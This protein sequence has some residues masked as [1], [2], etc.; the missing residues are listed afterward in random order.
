MFEELATNIQDSSSTVNSS[1][2]L[3]A[4]D[5]ADVELL[6][7]FA[8]LDMLK[9]RVSSPN[10]N[11]IDVDNSVC[12]RRCESKGESSGIVDKNVQN[13]SGEIDLLTNVYTNPGKAE[14]QK[15][16]STNQQVCSF[17]YLRRRIKT[18]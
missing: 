9:S 14:I 10:L 11:S 17:T 5:M 16:E 7:S 13:D 3:S 18:S 12:G 8:H 15:N 1:N 6:V 2:R 4:F